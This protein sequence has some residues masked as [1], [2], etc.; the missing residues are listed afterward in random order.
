MIFAVPERPPRRGGRRRRSV[1]LAAAAPTIRA[2]GRAGGWPCSP[3]NPGCRT[4]LAAGPARDKT[5]L[6]RSRSGAPSGFG[7]SQFAF[8]PATPS[9]R[10]RKP[11][12]GAELLRHDGGRRRPSPCPAWRAP[13]PTWPGSRA[14]PPRSVLA[15]R[16]TYGVGRLDRPPPAALYVADAA[17]L[18]IIQTAAGRSWRSVL[19]DDRR[20]GGLAKVGAGG[21]QSAVYAWAR[22]GGRGHHLRRRRSATT[23][24]CLPRICQVAHEALADP[25]PQAALRDRRQ[26]APSHARRGHRRRSCR[27]HDCSTC[28]ARGRS[29]PRRSRRS[30]P[31]TPPSACPPASWPS[32]AGPAPARRAR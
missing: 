9:R 27:G 2:A 30:P 18:Q 31:P 26:L 22:T 15:L 6:A 10:G 23:S 12:G 20:F 24:C 11:T 4:A 14:A 5:A 16:T 13:S 28:A 19:P 17:F 8:M 29:D 25:R 7:Q 21:R 1:R 3:A 32:T